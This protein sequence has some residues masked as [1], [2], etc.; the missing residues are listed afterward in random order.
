MKHSLFVGL[1][2]LLT[3]I[4]TVGCETQSRGFVLPPGDVDRG[5]DAFVA[6][7]CNRCHS[8][9]DVIDRDPATA[10]PAIHVVLGGATTRV[11]TYGDLVTSII[12]PS[13]K[14]A[15]GE[16]PRTVT[17]DGASKMPIY[18]DVMSVQQ[19]VDLTQFLQGSYEIWVPAFHMYNYYP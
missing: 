12:N 6:L 11:K 7:A 8:V 4:T 9:K 10:F 14:L 2:A 3:L 13:H 16:D 1:T 5:R 18:N 19:L 17:P 15:R